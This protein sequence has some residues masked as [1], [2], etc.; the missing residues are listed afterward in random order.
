MERLV[1]WRGPDRCRAEAAWVRLDDDRLTAHGTQLGAE[2]EPY[3]LDY[4]LLQ[5]SRS[6]G[7]AFV[8]ATCVSNPQPTSTGSD[9]L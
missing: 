4:T 3:R 8:S 5:A 9:P 7:I 1:L 2:P 6:T